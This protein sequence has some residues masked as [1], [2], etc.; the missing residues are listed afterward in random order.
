[1]KIKLKHAII[2][3][4]ATIPL[5][6]TAQLNKSE[7]KS[8]L[9]PLQYHVTQE[10]GTEKAF[11]N[12]YWNNKEAGLY[13]DIVSGEP[14]FASFDKYDSGSGWPS[15]TKPL[16]AKNIIER[17]DK[18]LFSSRTE[19]RSYKADSHLGHVFDDG[20]SPTHQRYCINSAALEFIPLEELTSRGYGEYLPLFKK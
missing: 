14:L 13:V 9:S 20:P 11:E 15:F 7:L 19:L 2:V 17:L 12:A 16:D 4:I 5:I 1:M 6:G 8:K 3:F 18:K 10:D